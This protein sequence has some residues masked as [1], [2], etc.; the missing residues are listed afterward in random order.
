MLGYCFTLRS[1]PA[2]IL[3][4]GAKIQ[5]WVRSVYQRLESSCG[6]LLRSYII[7]QVV[8]AGRGYRSAVHAEISPADVVD[9]DEDNVGCHFSSPK[10]QVGRSVFNLIS[11]NGLIPLAA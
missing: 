3:K 4:F 6:S 9:K 2:R 7:G 1:Y 10:I 8:D 11:S 5:P